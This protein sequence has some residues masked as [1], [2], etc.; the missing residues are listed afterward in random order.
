MVDNAKISIFAGSAGQEFAERMCKYLNMPLGKSSVIRF[1]DGNVFV[2]ADESVRDR[3]VYLV[4]PIG[5]RPN[6]EFT[7]ILFWM[8]AFKRASAASVVLVMPY[9]GYA[10][11]DK[12]DEPRVSIRA[13][14]C[15]ECMELAGAD[16]IMVM[17][18]HAS[19]VQGFFK[20][21]MDHLYAMPVLVEYIKTLN[22]EN[23]VVVSPDAGYAKQ[24]RR[25]GAALGLPVAIGDKQRTDHT[26]NAE[27]L[28]IIGEV[29]GRNALIVDDFSISGGTL[30]NLAKNLKDR[31]AKKI[32]AALSHN[33]L[34]AKGVER[35]EASPIDLVVSTDTVFN[36]NTKDH[37][38]FKTL[39][40]APIFA[41][42]IKRYHNYGSLND[43]SYR[44]PEDLFK[45]CAADVDED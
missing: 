36:A 17:D 4:Q 24:A 26:E 19:Q 1:S 31:G 28:E 16:R 27:V 18:L 45:A 2:R 20:R 40:V 21:P 44:L 32:I 11:G 13:R 12:K 25:F 34:S 42:S 29:E 14:V 3:T 5:F 37:P 8:D 43:L 41:E 39:S 10:K 7:E 35:I 9:F 23:T 22:L 38:R 33:I 15:A 6:D 30:I